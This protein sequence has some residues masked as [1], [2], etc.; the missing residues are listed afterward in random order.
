MY[1]INL[2][3]DNLN[4]VASTGAAQ[5][6]QTFET[7]LPLFSCCVFLISLL[8]CFI[9]LQFINHFYGTLT[10]SAELPIFK[11]KNDCWTTCP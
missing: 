2:K 4:C 3:N 8:A 11:R 10:F 9:I 5:M 7:Y 1:S 6:N